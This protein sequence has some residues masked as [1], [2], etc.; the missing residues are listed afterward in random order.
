V[1]QGFAATAS[2]TGE[3]AAKHRELVYRSFGNSGLVVSEAGFGGYRV[4]VSV[5]EHRQA[6]EH[7]LRSGINLID[8]SANYADGGSERLIGV[9]LK[10]MIKCREID[11]EQVVVVTKAG[12]LQGGNLELSRQRKLESQAFPDLVEYDEGMEHCI[13]PVFLEDQLTRSLQRL[14]LDSIDCYLLHNPEY[15][16]R[17][18]AHK[19]LDQ[20]AAKNEFLRRIRLAFAYLESEVRAGRI[21]CY[22]ISSNTFNKEETDYDHTSLAAIWQIACEISSQHHFQVIEMPMNL[23]EPEA[24]T[25]INQQGEKSVLSLAAEKRL[26]VLINRPLNAIVN[27][28]LVRLAENVYKKSAA[29]EATAF[30]ER[31]RQIDSDWQVSSLSRLA[32]RALRSTVGISS[33]LVG[34]RQFNYVDEVLSELALPCEKKIRLES[35]HKIAK[36]W[37]AG[38]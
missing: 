33:V 32:L 19:L 16:L 37:E 25:R 14:Q 10:D 36:A 21:G 27:D 34:M 26:G 3:Y 22:G 23:L 17:W 20:A 13:H 31:V 2:G 15:Y 8:T 18:A 29:R 30:C 7:A 5:A 38:R 12:Y 35:W 4:D 9:V 24:L 28:R 11:R 6:L 1:V